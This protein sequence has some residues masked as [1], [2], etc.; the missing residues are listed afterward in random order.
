MKMCMM[1][2]WTLFDSHVKTCVECGVPLVKVDCSIAA[3]EVDARLEELDRKA[4]NRKLRTGQYIRHHTVPFIM[5]LCPPGVEPTNI[6]RVFI[7]AEP[8]K[9]VVDPD[10]H[11]RREL[12]VQMY[13]AA[14]ADN[15]EE[16]ARL[17]DELKELERKED[18]ST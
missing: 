9:P 1:C 17:R 18:A 15:F 3:Q 14:N 4:H 8:V 5:N 7:G 16:A 2:G 10:A 13:A 11:Y 12:T 6:T